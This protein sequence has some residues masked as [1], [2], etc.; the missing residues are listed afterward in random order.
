[1]KNISR[2]K[3]LK[4]IPGIV[5]VPSVLA[6]CGGSDGGTTPDTTGPSIADI[7]NDSYEGL[8]TV[9]ADVSDPSGVSAVGFQ[10]RAA[11]SADAY[12]IVP[13][14]NAGGN[15]WTADID[16]AS[17]EFEYIINAADGLGNPRQVT[18]N[19]RKYANEIN[20]DNELVSRAGHYRDTTSEIS[21]YWTEYTFD[22]GGTLV[23]VDLAVLTNALEFNGGWY[24]GP[25]DGDHAAEKAKMEEYLTPWWQINACP[26][27][28]IAGKLDEIKDAGWVSGQ[29]K[30]KTAKAK[31]TPFDRKIASSEE[32]KENCITY[33]VFYNKAGQKV[34]RDSDGLREYYDQ[35]GNV[36]KEEQL[37]EN[38]EVFTATYHGVKFKDGNIG[39]LVVNPSTK[40]IKVNAPMGFLEKVF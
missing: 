33:T 39:S 5:A 3:F 29:V 14:V 13:M 24:Q 25:A 26:A 12:T 4:C 38:G 18:G 36:Y 40:T 11:G 35:T 1:M 21:D 2:R 34:R 23:Q 22:F 27:D 9:S 16:F 19:V 7:V 6:G 8:A 37:G 10:Y 30:A 32:V 31:Q 28:E 17:D 15:T 20:G